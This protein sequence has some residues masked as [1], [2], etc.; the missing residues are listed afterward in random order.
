MKL[1][2]QLVEFEN[3]KKEIWYN[4]NSRHH[5]KLTFLYKIIGVKIIVICLNQQNILEPTQPV[6]SSLTLAKGRIPA[7]SLFLPRGPKEEVP[8]GIKISHGFL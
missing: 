1:F 7:H 6:S 8:R 4:R 5:A 2:A 3:V